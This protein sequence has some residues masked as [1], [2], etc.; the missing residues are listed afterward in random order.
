MIQITPQQRQQILSTPEFA[1]AFDTAT[2]GYKPEKYPEVGKFDFARTRML[3]IRSFAS[4]GM[5][6]DTYVELN[7]KPMKELEWGILQKI[8]AFAIDIIPDAIEW[9]YIDFIR[10]FHETLQEIHDFTTSK[11]EE[12]I[13]SVFL[14]LKAKNSL[15]K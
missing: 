15:I 8:C 9:D 12:C 5:D 4:F 7:N 11:R 13:K 10:S 3:T 1:K 2:T 6:F 14:Q